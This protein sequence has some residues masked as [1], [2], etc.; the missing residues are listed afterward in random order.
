[1][2][3]PVFG[4]LQSF[5]LFLI[6]LFSMGL[7]ISSFVL[8]E[9]FPMGFPVSFLDLPN[10]FPVLFPVPLSFR[11]VLFSMGPPILSFLGSEVFPMGFPVSFLGL[12]NFSRFFSRYL[13]LCSATPTRRWSRASIILTISSLTLSDMVVVVFFVDRWGMVV[14]SE[15]S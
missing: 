6:V 4:C 5:S 11:I 7:P 12:Q 14:V 2:T 1:M 15:A 8:S 13:V 9:L 10:F 3:R